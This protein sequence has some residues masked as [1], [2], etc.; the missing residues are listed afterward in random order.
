MGKNVIALALLQDNSLNHYSTVKSD[1]LSL[2]VRLD[3]AFKKYESGC[4]TVG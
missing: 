2:P 1:D 4:Q 3:S